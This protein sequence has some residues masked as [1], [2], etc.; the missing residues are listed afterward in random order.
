ME[1]TKIKVVYERY[2][3]HEN[4]AP[5]IGHITAPTLREAI[6]K[7]LS[8]IGMYLDEEGIQ[9]KE[10]E[11][12]REMTQEELIDELYMQ[13]GD[14]CDYILSLTNEVTGEVY[15]ESEEGFEEWTI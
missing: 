11:L 7:M 15:M 9:E 10:E 1:D 3:R 5:A 13:N 4:L 8:K 6:I 14:G 2:A 12:G